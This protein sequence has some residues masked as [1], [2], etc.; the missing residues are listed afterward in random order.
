MDMD[1]GPLVKCGRLSGFELFC[2]NPRDHHDNA[3][4]HPSHSKC[5]DDGD[6]GG[7]V[8]LFPIGCFDF[9]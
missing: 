2:S 1:M 9:F 4:S 8:F 7:L 6:D 5:K 3:A